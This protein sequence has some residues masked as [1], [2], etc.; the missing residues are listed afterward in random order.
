M[1]CRICTREAGPERLVCDACYTRFDRRIIHVALGLDFAPD[2]GAI[3][4]QDRADFEAARQART[5]F[6]KAMEAW[7]MDE[8]GGDK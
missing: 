4:D 5:S 8:K 1:Q 2:R 6:V 3:T 7:K